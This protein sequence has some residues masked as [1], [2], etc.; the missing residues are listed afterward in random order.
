MSK[1]KKLTESELSKLQ[2]GSIFNSTFFKNPF[3]K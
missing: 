1:L 2:G 3:K